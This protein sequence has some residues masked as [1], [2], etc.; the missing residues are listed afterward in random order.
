MAERTDD[1]GGLRQA[2]RRFSYVN[3]S[4]HA[5]WY[6]QGM[7]LPF[8]SLGLKQNLHTTSAIFYSPF[9]VHALVFFVNILC[10]ESLCI[11]SCISMMK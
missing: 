7:I 9:L 4:G 10:K 1:E 2:C 11:G 3:V 5:S 8:V 6:R